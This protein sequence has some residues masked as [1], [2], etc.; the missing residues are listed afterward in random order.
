MGRRTEFYRSLVLF[1]IFSNAPASAEGV[2][3]R[4]GSAKTLTLISKGSAPAVKQARGTDRSA[5]SQQGEIRVSISTTQAVGY[6]KLHVYNRNTKTVTFEIS[7]MKGGRLL[8]ESELCGVAGT[9]S[10]IVLPPATAY[11]RLSRFAEIGAKCP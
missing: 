1:S 8:G 2:T 9:D 7:A 4:D 5:V 6:S 10:W 3:L 11:I